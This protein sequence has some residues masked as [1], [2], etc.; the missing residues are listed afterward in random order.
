MLT[1]LTR[2]LLSRTSVGSVLSGTNWLRSSILIGVPMLVPGC[3]DFI[4]WVDKQQK[5]SR[6][7][8]FPKWS[9][10]GRPAQSKKQSPASFL[11]IITHFSLLKWFKVF[12]FY[13]SAPWFWS[14]GWRP[15]WGNARERWPSGSCWVRWATGS[16]PSAAS[17]SWT[18]RGFAPPAPRPPETWPT[19]WRESPRRSSSE[20]SR[21][22]WGSCRSSP[23][24]SP[25]HGHTYTSAVILREI[26]QFLLC[27]VGA[28]LPCRLPMMTTSSVNETIF[29]SWD[30]N[31]SLLIRDLI[32]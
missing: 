23:F 22:R 11:S 12:F 3:E 21:G 32:H 31:K 4:H 2:F 16:S 26:F 30:E 14:W 15:H 25:G 6:K 5:Q 1:P 7:N 18:W 27:C 10:E 13:V 19:R 24:C 8:I 17:A 9:Q 20:A 29:Q 28:T